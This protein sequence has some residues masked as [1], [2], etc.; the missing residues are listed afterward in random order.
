MNL[1]RLKGLVKDV[2]DTV[3]GIEEIQGIVVNVFDYIKAKRERDG[4]SYTSQKIRIRDLEDSSVTLVVNLW[5]KPQMSEDAVGKKLIVKS[6]L[7]TF[8]HKASM[9]GVKISRHEYTP[10]GKTKK[11]PYTRAEVSQGAYLALGESKETEAELDSLATTA[12]PNRSRA[13]HP[14]FA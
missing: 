8:H 11:V 5:S 2:G 6:V 3:D 9:K 7:R 14:R 4:G 10:K 12:P 13:S 1:I